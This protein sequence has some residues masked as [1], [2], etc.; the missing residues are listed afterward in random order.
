MSRD[1]IILFVAAVILISGG[2]FLLAQAKAY[3]VRRN[4]SESIKC[5][6]F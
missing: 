6:R 1:Y 4:K 2:L 5:G 3:Q